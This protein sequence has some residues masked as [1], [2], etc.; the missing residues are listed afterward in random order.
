MTNQQVLMRSRPQG[1]VTEDH[2]QLVEGDV[3]RPAAG[4]VLIRNQFLSLDP[5]MRGR[6]GDALSYRKGVDPGDVMPGE[7]AGE[8]IE[9]QHPAFPVGDT[10]VAYTGWQLYAALPGES[11]RKVDASRIPLSYFLGVIGM[12]G[13]TAYFGLNEIGQPKSGE[14]VVV[15]GAAGAVGGIV[16]QI[17]A[18]RG[19]RVIGIAGG[20]EK[21]DYATGELGFDA[22]IDYKA[23]RVFDDLRAAAP[24]GIDVYWDNVGGE[25][26]DTALAQANTFARVV[27]CG[28]I[29]QYNAIEPYG[30]KNYRS[31]LVN[32]IRMQGMIVHDWKARFPEAWSQ[33][34]E[35]FGSGQLVYRETI[36]D[37]LRNAPAAFL[38]LLK[39]HNI[40]KQIV[41]LSA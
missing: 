31:V 23:G 17:S 10:V 11:V 33:L 30:L 36:A 15:S 5:Y 20:R 19:C 24:N 6:M 8:V 25:I 21:C 29:S 7:A 12:P 38:G 27:V 32:R 18:H 28:T 16:G 4:E 1:W 34:A 37:E 41:R 9:S 40:G 3:P 22:C 35:W 39:G 14:T 26:L 13:C 2:F